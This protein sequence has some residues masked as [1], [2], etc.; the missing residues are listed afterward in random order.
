MAEVREMLYFR[1]GRTTAV[2]RN[3]ACCGVTMPRF[4]EDDDTGG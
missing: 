2:V 4:G 1:D 3:I